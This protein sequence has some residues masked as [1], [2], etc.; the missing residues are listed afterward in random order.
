MIVPA[1]WEIAVQVASYDPNM[2]LLCFFAWTLS[3]IIDKIASLFLQLP[4]K[5]WNEFSPST[6][7]QFE[8][9]AKQ[10]NLIW[11]FQRWSWQRNIFFST[12]SSF[13]VRFKVDLHSIGK[14]S[15]DIKSLNTNISGNIS[16]R[17][18]ICKSIYSNEET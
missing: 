10:S 6:T 9:L 7:I 16:A 15:L 8:T 17:I 4:K 2:Q 13:A 12:I 11:T 1:L 3:V 18:I 5:N 14:T